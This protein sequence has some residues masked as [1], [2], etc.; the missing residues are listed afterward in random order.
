VS[1]TCRSALAWAA[2]AWRRKLST[3][4]SK[5]TNAGDRPRTGGNGEELEITHALVSGERYGRA[6]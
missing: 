6:W 3:E 1:T 5:C 2:T 4:T